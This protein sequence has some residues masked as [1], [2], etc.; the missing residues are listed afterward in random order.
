MAVPITETGSDENVL[1]QV[2]AD[3][4]NP[5]VPLTHTGSVRNKIEQIATDA[6]VAIPAAGSDRNAIEALA[7][8]LPNPA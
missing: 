8:S 6:G 3:N 2:V 5:A 1:R 4:N 7:A